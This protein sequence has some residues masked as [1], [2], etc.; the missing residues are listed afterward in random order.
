MLRSLD[1]ILKVL[2]SHRRFSSK[3]S[4]DQTLIC[5]NYFCRSLTIGSVIRGTMMEAGK[6][7]RRLFSDRGLKA[8]E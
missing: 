8:R 2:E 6:L 4:H 1:I 7:V 3:K 5:E